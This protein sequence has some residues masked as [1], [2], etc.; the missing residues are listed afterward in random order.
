MAEYADF[1]ASTCQF[2]YLEEGKR[3]A[4]L[5]T[6]SVWVTFIDLPYILFALATTIPHIPAKKKEKKRK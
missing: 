5:L 6:L 3:L 2:P 4:A 1:P